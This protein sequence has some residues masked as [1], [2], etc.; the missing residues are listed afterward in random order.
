VGDLTALA[1]SVF[2]EFTD[3][4]GWAGFRM[5]VDTASST[6]PLGEFTREVS[7]VH[8]DLIGAIFERARSRGESTG[9]VEPLAVTDIIYG[10]GLFFSLGCRLDNRTPGEDELV[11]RVDDVVTVLV[12]GLG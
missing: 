5:I 3:P 12:R 6:N 10:A 9:D 1:T 2:R 8:R 11:T 7:G 4:E